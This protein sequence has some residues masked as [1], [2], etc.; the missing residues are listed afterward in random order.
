M[1]IAGEWIWV[2][3]GTFTVQDFVFVDDDGN[4]INR[5][6]EPAYHFVST[7][8]DPYYG[9]LSAIQLIKLRPPELDV[10]SSDGRRQGLPEARSEARAEAADEPRPEAAPTGPTSGDAAVGAPQPAAAASSSVADQLFAD[11]I[12]M[13]SSNDPDESGRG[14]L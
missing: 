7:N 11:P 5:S 3:P 8:G 10:L 13:P 14:L 6:G 2:E 12:P 1:I 9:P 4:E